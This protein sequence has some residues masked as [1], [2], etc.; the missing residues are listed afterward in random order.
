VGRSRRATIVLTAME[1]EGHTRTSYQNFPWPNLEQ[2]FVPNIHISSINSKV[3]LL[4]CGVGGV[5]PSK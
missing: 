5:E 3:E 1:V 4:L 2:S